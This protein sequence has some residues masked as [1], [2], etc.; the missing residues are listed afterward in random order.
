MA[1]DL[2]TLK[3]E[4]AKLQRQIASLE[5]KNMAEPQEF[6]V[7]NKPTKTPEK[8]LFLPSSNN[9]LAWIGGVIFA[10]GL[11]FFVAYAFEQGWVTK[12]LQIL[13]GVA[14]GAGLMA[15]G[16]WMSKKR[17]LQGMLIAGGGLAVAYFSIYAGYA[18]PSYREALGISFAVTVVLLAAVMSAGVYLSA[19]LKSSTLLVETMM[20][21]HLALFLSDLG[22][23]TIAYLF[24]ITAGFSA[25]VAANAWRNAAYFGGAI[26]M[27]TV[28]ILSA[29]LE[30]TQAL[31]LIAGLFI[32][33]TWLSVYRNN[34]LAQILV[35]TGTFITGLTA[36][37]NAPFPEH[38][39]VGMLAIISL[40]FALSIRGE[41]HNKWYYVAAAAFAA[42][43]VP[44]ALE[45][46][47]VTPALFTLVF[48][49]GIVGARNKQSFLAET[50]DII[51]VFALL[52]LLLF[53]TWI[54][55][56]ISRLVAF[57]F[58][59]AVLLI[60]TWQYTVTNRQDKHFVLAG[61][62]IA[63]IVWALI[64]VPTIAK[65]PALLGLAGA[66]FIAGRTLQKPELR[67]YA[68]AVLGVVLAKALLYDTHALETMGRALS[69]GL[70]VLVL[71]LLRIFDDAASPY[72]QKA[73]TI[74]AALIAVL[75]IMIE[76]SGMQI[77]LL[78]G[79]AGA[80]SYTVGTTKNALEAKI[81]GIVL[82][83]MSVLKLFLIDTLT[84]SPGLRIIAYITLGA[85]LLGASLFYSRSKQ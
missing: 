70:F 31:V 50:A 80:I 5:K 16:V 83:S 62:L 65:T 27:F 41:R 40:A 73:Y 46:A 6:H 53:D 21:A 33:Y 51:V 23:L 67:Y 24:I 2:K 85:L 7:K 64:D 26:S 63:L 17:P 54:I 68:H 22:W 76:L 20:L 28:L 25:F 35:I 59:G 11:L 74:L 1:D 39:F 13:L 79:L 78:L 14:A 12:P 4:Q 15:A 18:A 66:V 43:W 37:V 56:D 19:R 77:T 3:K 47:Y 48:I 72:L 82:I 10:L 84:L 9:I 69:L 75:L 57:I 34:R 71:I 81:V 36:A 38:Y 8:P 49:L 32:I 61:F 29:L 45:N 55:D 30:Y 42:F 60:L 58:A 52:K 44:V